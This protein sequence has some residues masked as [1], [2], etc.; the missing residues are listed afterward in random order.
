MHVVASPVVV[1]QSRH[2]LSVFG[3]LRLV[4]VGCGSCVTVRLVGVRC[5][6][7]CYGV[8]RLVLAMFGSHGAFL[9]GMF[10]FVSLGS[11][12]AV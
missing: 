4:T 6:T 3:K 5:V 9:H 1:R 11:G 7:A 8:V 2:V 10:L 12:K